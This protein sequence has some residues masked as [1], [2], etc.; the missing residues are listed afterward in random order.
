MFGLSPQDGNGNRSYGRNT[1]PL[2]LNPFN[3]MQCSRRH[4]TLAAMRTRDHGNVFDY[5]QATTLTIATRNVTHLTAFFTAGITNK[6]FVSIRSFL[7]RL[8]TESPS[9]LETASL[10][11]QSQAGNKTRRRRI[12]ASSLLPCLTHP[13]PRPRAA[14]PS[15]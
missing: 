3:L 1:E 9:H 2:T 10:D 13:A 6:R 5:K 11:L 15:L 8:K 7:H 4:I 14:I 12:P